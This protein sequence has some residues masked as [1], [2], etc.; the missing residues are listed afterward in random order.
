MSTEVEIL[1]K[2]INEIDSQL[3]WMYAE[4]RELEAEKGELED[5]KSTLVNAKI[6]EGELK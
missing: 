5:Y 2:R 6:A 1:E 3:G 4:M